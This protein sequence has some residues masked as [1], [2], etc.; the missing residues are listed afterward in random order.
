MAASIG[1]IAGPVS[2]HEAGPASTSFSAPITVV[3]VN[4]LSSHAGALTVVVSLAIYGPSLLYLGL[5]VTVITPNVDTGKI[6]SH[7]ITS[8]T[9]I[10]TSVGLAH[11]CA[12]KG[13]DKLTLEGSHSVKIPS[14]EET[15][16]PG[17]SARILSALAASTVTCVTVETTSLKGYVP[18]LAV[19]PS[20][21]LATV[22]ST[23]AST[24]TPIPG[25]NCGCLTD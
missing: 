3:L 22:M 13:T 23:V 4:T 20:G 17:A 1:P 24:V 18:S 9:L 21:D 2:P 7:G 16:S 6:S 19:E 12:P 5:I 14:E 10:A 25:S 11:V 15:L 8:V